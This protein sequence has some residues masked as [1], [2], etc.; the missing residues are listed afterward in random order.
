MFTGP[1]QTNHLGISEDEAQ[2]SEFEADGSG[3][4]HA[5]ER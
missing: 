1:S 2:E 5:H 3:T 4:K